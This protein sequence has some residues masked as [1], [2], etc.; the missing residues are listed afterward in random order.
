MKQLVFVF[1]VVGLM[2]SCAV[3]RLACVEK[4][5]INDG[6]A[7]EAMYVLSVFVPRDSLVLTSMAKPVRNIKTK[8]IQKLTSRMLATVHHPDSRGV[9]IAAPQVGISRQVI[10]VQRFDKEERPFEACFNP[11]IVW[12]SEL[13]TAY[14][15]GCLSVP[16]YRGEVERPDTVDVKYQDVHGIWKIERIQGFTARIFQHEIDH[17]NGILY[18]ELIT[19]PLLPSQH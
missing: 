4:Q 1:L 3:S 16:G 17:L 10:L 7:D 12:L 11:K 18:T 2:Q 15:E 19:G 13:K 14:K 8:P 6:G 9:G 5:R